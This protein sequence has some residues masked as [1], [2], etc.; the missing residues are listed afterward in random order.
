MCENIRHF[1]DNA[2]KNWKLMSERR[3]P[4]THRCQFMFLN[5]TYLFPLI[6][7]LLSVP[8]VLRK[9][10]TVQTENISGTEA[11]FSNTSNTFKKFRLLKL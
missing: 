8:A 4:N 1:S 6:L 2:F 9:E 10:N 5:C 11:E 7:V 3:K